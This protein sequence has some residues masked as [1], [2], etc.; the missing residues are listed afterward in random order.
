MSLSNVNNLGMPWMHSPFE[1]QI[2]NICSVRSFVTQDDMGN[3][4]ST[5][6]RIEFILLRL[7]MPKTKS[8]V[9]PS[10]GLLGMGSGVYKLVFLVWSLY[11]WQTLQSWRALRTSSCILGQK[12]LSSMSTKVLNWPKWPSWSP[13]I[14][15]VDNGLTQWTLAY[16]QLATLKQGPIL[17]DLDCWRDTVGQLTRFDHRHTSLSG[18]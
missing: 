6:S 1:K 3:F 14:Q 12:N 11:V 10:Q 13:T 4:W 9:S 16:A 8:T 18:N 5:T 17:N 15:L 7:D 2:N